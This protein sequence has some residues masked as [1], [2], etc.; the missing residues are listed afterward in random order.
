MVD[1][2]DRAYDNTDPDGTEAANTI[3]T[4]I[5]NKGHDVWQRF[6][7]QH[8]NATSKTAVGGMHIPGASGVLGRY[9]TAQLASIAAGAPTDNNV[10]PAEVDT[11]VVF[12]TTRQCL[13]SYHLTDTTW[14]P[15][16]PYIAA[17]DTVTVTTTDFSSFAPVE[18]VTAA[19]TS[20]SITNTIIGKQL[21]VV[22]AFIVSG[23]TNGWGRIRA[24][25]DG[26][27]QQPA[28][29]GK[30]IAGNSYFNF[31]GH[32]PITQTTTDVEIQLFMNSAS[33]NPLSMKGGYVRCTLYPLGITA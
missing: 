1:Y 31:T 14:Y 18:L 30:I 15:V 22:D 10:I 13:C 6:I 29:S 32:Y 26:V 4:E 21:L 7:I 9:T 8:S 19:G 12:D 20:I 23:E 17:Y 24:E 5:I 27:A 3:D 33:D 16:T 28:G 25:I 2:F 11:A